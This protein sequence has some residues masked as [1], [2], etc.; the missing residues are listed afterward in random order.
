M[1]TSA[2]TRRFLL[3]RPEVA[4]LVGLSV[5]SVDR[6]IRAGDLVALRIGPGRRLV[7]VR[8]SDI[9]KWIDRGARTEEGHPDA[10]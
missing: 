1:Q 9:L 8:R 3:T 7:R 6:A 2:D 5:A 10:A 4:D